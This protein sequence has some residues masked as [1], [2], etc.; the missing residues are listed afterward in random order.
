MNILA[1]VLKSPGDKV[2]KI[3]STWIVRAT[4]QLSLN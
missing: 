4:I 3:I 1:N 2:S